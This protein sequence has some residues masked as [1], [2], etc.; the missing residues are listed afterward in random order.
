[1]LKPTNMSMFPELSRE[2]IDAIFD[3]VDAQEDPANKAA[4]AGGGDASGPVVEESGNTWLWVV[5]GI[6][7][8]VIILTLSGVRRQLSQVVA[9][10][11]GKPAEDFPTYGA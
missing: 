2:D 8:I 5:A 6:I 3:Y 10:K 1:K 7:F 9:E 4:A 11:E